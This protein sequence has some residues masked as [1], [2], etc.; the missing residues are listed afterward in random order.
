MITFTS[1]VSLQY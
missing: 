1:A